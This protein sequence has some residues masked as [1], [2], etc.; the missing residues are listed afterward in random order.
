MAISAEQLNVILSARDRE[1]TR[2]M[3]RAERRV[4]RFSNQS[5][6][7]LSQTSQAWGALGM[8]VKAFLPA[9][10]AGV[11]VSEMRRVVSEGARIENLARLAGTTSEEFQR[12]AAGARTVGFD[13]DKT[14][15]IIKDV[16]DKVGDFLSTGAGP[17]ADFFENVAPLVGVTAD[18]FRRLSGQEAL[19][20]YVSSLEKANLSQ[21]EMTFYMEAI[22]ND[23]TALL[24]L[25]TNNAQEMRSLGAAADEAGTILSNEMTASAKEAELELGKMSAVISANLSKALLDLSPL[26]VTAAQGIA[27]LTGYVATFLETM[28]AAEAE[29]G[30]NILQQRI[31]DTQKLLDLYD[32]GDPDAASRLLVLGG[33][34]AARE[35]LAKLR[36]E[37]EALTQTASDTAENMVLPEVVIDSA[38]DLSA[39]E[40]MVEL[41]REEAR[42]AQLTAEERER[43]RIAKEAEAAVT[44]AI[45]DQDLN[46]QETEEVERLRQA[47]VD[48]ATAASSILNPVKAAGGATR[49]IADAAADAEE[50]ITQ[51]IERMID[52]S[53]A[54]KQLGFDAENLQGVMGTVQSS[55][56]NAF[57]GMLDGT[58]TAGDAFRAM[59]ADIIRELYRVLVVQRLVGSFTAGGG[60][61]MGGL[62]GA[63]GGR[64]SGGPVQAGQPYTVGE[65]G[66]ELFVPS[67]SGRVLSA[68]QTQNAMR[69]DG[70]VTIHQTFQFSA[71]GDESV[72][73]IIAQEAPK[74]AAL[75]Q[76]QIVDQ[77]RRGGAM[78][79][80]FG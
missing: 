69:G 51:M 66:R 1:F 64:A 35:N 9:L 17:M 2:A 70:G 29:S 33:V 76:K 48:A 10:S 39:L 36:E 40:Q 18:Q 52:A 24:P 26:L 63:L 74:I 56:E 34:D 12:F 50:N 57:M 14:A 58:A 28:K 41:Q 13:M 4:Q 62:F 5:N 53:P 49:E 31:E 23:A 73:R 22:A 60:G 30:T 38:A 6:R 3:E 21:S 59:A 44:K 55:M 37:Y 46:A 72:K 61:I 79:G 20:L 80:A 75:T 15:D 47:Y 78:K 65:H 43:A 8:Q 77:R 19:M 16:N 45:A 42:L 27:G 25:L 32:S 68:A 54:L 67:T 11:L 7:N 71:N